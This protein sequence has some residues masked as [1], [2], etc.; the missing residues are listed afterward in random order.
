MRKPKHLLT[1]ILV[2]FSVNAV[3][4]DKGDRRKLPENYVSDNCSWFPDGDY[5][6]CCVEHDKDYFFGGTWRERRAAD[7][8]LVE[9]VNRKGHRFISKIM[10]LGVRIGG[11]PFLP[12][13]FRWGFGKD[14][15]KKNPQ[16]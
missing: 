3:L 1:F 10:W 6:D 13:S 7:K 16:K 8:R 2:A 12:S 11:V 14:W 15:E 5:G 9:C 4:A